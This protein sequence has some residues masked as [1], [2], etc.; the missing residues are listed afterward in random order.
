MSQGDAEAIGSGGQ[1]ETVFGS[2]VGTESEFTEN[3]NPPSGGDTYF[4]GKAQG[5]RDMR[6]K[7]FNK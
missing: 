6:D 5:I 7:Y 4:G 2:G 3:N 1:V